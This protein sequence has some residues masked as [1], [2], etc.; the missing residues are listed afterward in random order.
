MKDLKKKDKEK[1]KKFLGRP[2]SWSSIYL[3]KS[4]PD[5]WYDK[6]FGEVKERPSGPAIFGK[7]V[8]ARIEAE[9]D[10]LPEVPRL[11][12]FQH[13]IHVKIGSV[14]CIGFLD[15]FSEEQKILIERKTGKKW[16]FKR[17]NTHGQLTMY[18]S[19]IYLKYGIRPEDLT[20]KLIWL[21]TEQRLLKTDFI[22]DMKPVI[23]PV[24]KTMRDILSFMAEIQVIHKE[25]LDYIYSK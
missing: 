7:N 8:D 25:M 2:L 13:K 10:F 1:I 4:D 22:R 14:D 5:K 20:I 17:A 23:Y 21:P 9:T 12:G 16:D 11:G 19:M 6:Y 18:A 24:K 3:F 15:D